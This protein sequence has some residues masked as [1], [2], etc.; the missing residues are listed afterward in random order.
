MVLDFLAVDNF[1]FTRN[2]VKKFWVKILVNV[3]DLHF[4]VVDKFNFPKK[5]AK[6][7]QNQIFGQK[8]DLS[9]SVIRDLL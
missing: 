5:I 4:L 6:F 9:N 8:F 7:C 1:D 2:I 3:G